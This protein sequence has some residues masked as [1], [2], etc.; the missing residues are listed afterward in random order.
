MIKNDN[1]KVVRYPAS[2]LMI[3]HIPCNSNWTIDI[4]NISQKFEILKKFKKFFQESSKSS[5]F[6]IIF[7]DSGRQKFKLFKV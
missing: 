4:L 1:T 6:S 7:K 3:K 2:L 5:K